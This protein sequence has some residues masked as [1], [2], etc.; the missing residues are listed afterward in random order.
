MYVISTRTFLS[1]Y[2]V[3]KKK[4][5]LGKKKKQSLQYQIESKWFTDN[6]VETIWWLQLKAPHMSMWQAPFQVRPNDVVDRRGQ[7]HMHREDGPN[8]KL[9]M[10]Q[11]AMYLG[12]YLNDPTIRKTKIA[13][14]PDQY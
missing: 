2:D 1:N 6:F 4:N 12:Q 9:K 14:M 10:L 8:T 3:G 13:R 5:N 7:P 11:V